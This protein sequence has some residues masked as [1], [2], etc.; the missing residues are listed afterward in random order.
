MNTT[1]SIIVRLLSNLGS[2]REVGQY[3][4]EFSGAPAEKFGLI[5][6][7]GG[8]VEDDLDNLA[9]ALTF[10][11]QVGLFPIVIHGAGPQLDRALKDEGIESE[12]RNGM[13]I[14]TERI[15][16]IARRTFQKVNLSLVEALE[17]LD[18]RARP[19]VSGVFEADFLDRESLGY[20]G[21]VQGV[22]L[23]Q[24]HSA[25]RGGQLPILACLGETNAGQILNINADVA[26]REFALAV[27]PY[28]IIFLTP[29]GGLLDDRDRIIS[30]INLAEDY[31]GLMSQPWVAGG[32]RLKLEQ[33]HS[34]LSGLPHTSSVSITAPDHLAKE[35]FTHQGSGTLI[36]R[37]ER[38]HA[39]PS[40]DL[41]DRERLQSLL[42]ACF[43]RRLIEDYFDARDLERLFLADSYRATAIV[44][45]ENGMAY[46]DKF[47]VTAEAQGVG[48]GGSVWSRMRGEFPRLFWRSRSGNPINTWYFQ[49]AQGSFRTDEWVVFWC[50][51]DSHEQI[52][53]CV[54]C[55]LA[56]PASLQASTIV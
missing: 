30:A 14:T 18:T 4:K 16:E 56:L 27:Q 17:G 11:Q 15:L 46:L 44:T 5:K 33:I 3:L 51:M 21:A 7:G 6:V 29:T 47:A 10:L 55:A 45:R 23:D 20:V 37:G 24:V 8:I 26:A 38:I 9:S 52:R 39:H 36:R 49:Q 43:Q 13:R 12:H 32:M 40:F 54:E 1:R 41:V 22:H 31:E 35:L 48:L 2:S 34:L 25:I 50:G 28:K 53:S 42:E 19:I